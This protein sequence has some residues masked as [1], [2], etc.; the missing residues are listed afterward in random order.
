[1]KNELNEILSRSPE[2][3]SDSDRATIQAATAPLKN[4]T[5]AGMTDTEREFVRDLFVR[6]CSHYDIKK[7][8]VAYCVLLAG[9]PAS[10]IGLLQLC[11][12]KESENVENN[13]FLGIPA[14]EF[15]TPAYMKFARCIMLKN[16][17][18]Y[19]ESVAVNGKEYGHAYNLLF[20][21]TL[22]EYI[23]L[24]R[25][26]IPGVLFTQDRRAKGKKDEAPPPM[27]AATVGRI[28][29]QAANDLGFGGVGQH[30]QFHRLLD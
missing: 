7:R 5:V 18:V 22:T 25:G 30:L 19:I 17:P 12:A 11:E 14:V 3:W 28:M 13:S 27:S 1:M 9:V 2:S 29:R 15:Y 20:R 24:S 8:A 23:H 21:I 26:I 16:K 10:Q 6:Y 4:K